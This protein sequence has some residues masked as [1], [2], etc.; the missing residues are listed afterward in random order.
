M[1][2]IELDI[3]RRIDHQVEDIPPPRAPTPEYGAYIAKLCVRCHGERFSGGPMPGTP[4]SLAVPSNLTPDPS[5]LADWTYED[6][7]K[8]LTHGIRKNGKPLDP[9]MS[10]GAMGKMDETEKRA[11]WAYL[12]MLP[13]RQFGGH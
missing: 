5:G 6:L 9:F 10:L 13:P 8:L 1:N 7:D 4:P 12:R 11:L 3:A 2:L